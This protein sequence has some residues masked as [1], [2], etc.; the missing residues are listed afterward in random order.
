MQKETGA[1]PSMFLTQRLELGLTLE[2]V[3]KGICSVSY[4]SMI[5]AGKRSPSRKIH[6]AL[7]YRLGLSPATERT[8]G[9]SALL[10]RCLL[11]LRVGDLDAARLTIN[12]LD[13]PAER[14]LIEGRLLERDGRLDEALEL[15]VPCLENNG[16]GMLIKVL[17]A[18]AIVRIETSLTDYHR[19]IQVGE[20]ALSSLR[21]NSELFPDEYFELKA[22]LAGVYS[23]VGDLNRAMSL[24]K[25]NIAGH[26]S[27][28]SRV[29][30]LWTQSNILHSAGDSSEAALKAECALE[31]AKA[32]DRPVALAHM[33]QNHAYYSLKSGK[34]DISIV[35]AELSQAEQ[36]FRA[37]KAHA[38]LATCLDTQ[39][40]ARWHENKWED[41]L[42]LLREAYATMPK[43]DTAARAKLLLSSAETYMKLNA[44][45]DAKNLLVE[46]RQLLEKQKATRAEAQAWRTMADIYAELDDSTSVIACLK[47]A[48]DL[49]GLGSSTLVVG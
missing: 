34:F 31:I 41:S 2:Q 35:D 9:E 43:H 19:A 12:L 26:D 13:N 40:L 7:C 15:L 5:E 21:E 8:A 38:A 27:N 28:W 32:I 17:A 20:S 29:M 49:L 48:T 18:I 42:A 3:A 25:D 14:D 36:V 45:I 44:R 10:N 47:A 23:E 37:S 39:A 4:L 24:V 22:V 1:Q 16:S 11:A 33:Q 46:A 30:Q 6:V